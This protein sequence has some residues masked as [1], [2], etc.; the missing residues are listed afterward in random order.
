MTFIQWTFLERWSDMF[1]GFVQSDSQ[2]GVEPLY[3]LLLRSPT[4]LPEKIKK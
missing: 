4:N 2:V 3:S 1:E